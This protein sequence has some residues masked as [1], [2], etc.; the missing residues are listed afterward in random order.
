[1]LCHLVHR[2]TNIKYVLALVLDF[3][4]TKMLEP[5]STGTDRSVA[6]VGGGR[7]LASIFL[8]IVVCRARRQRFR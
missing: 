8:W 6:R 2:F 1:M 5:I 7:D 3:I 4:G